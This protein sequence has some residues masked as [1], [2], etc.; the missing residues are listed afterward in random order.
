MYVRR[1][2]WPYTLQNEDVYGLTLDQTHIP[3]TKSQSSAD[4]SSTSNYSSYSNISNVSGY[5]L[6]LKSRCTPATSPTSI[7]RQ[8]YATSEYGSDP[9][10]PKNTHPDYQNEFM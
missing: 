3:N 8:T 4:S 2:I 10:T 9:D 7:S 1:K 6:P 5:D